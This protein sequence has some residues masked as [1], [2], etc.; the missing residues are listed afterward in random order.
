VVDTLRQDEPL[1]AAAAEQLHAL[2][3]R[4]II[5]LDLGQTSDPTAMAVVED[6]LM[7]DQETGRWVSFYACRYLKR[8]KLRTKYPDI[9]ED[10]ARLVRDPQLR[11]PVLVIDNTGVGRSVGDL[12]QRAD[13]SARL[14]RV[15]ITGG[16]RA[17]QDED[18]CWLVPKKDL[19]GVLQTLLQS[20]RLAFAK[21]LPDRDVLVKE[22]NAFR[23]KITAA[24]NEVMG[25]WREGEHDDLVLALALA[26]WAAEHDG[27]GE[28][29]AMPF[30][31]E[32][33]GKA[34]LYRRD[35]SMESSAFWR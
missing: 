29:P 17:H 5:G 13:L 23:V 7:L 3:R 18:G 9:V 11:A 27:E 2:P 4:H 12:F 15:T 8:W 22:L 28:A 19:I 20:K 34:P 1:R 33:R 21:G 35:R 25:A 24:L 16:H 30:M 10:V 14:R 32:E 6:F 31:L 26:C